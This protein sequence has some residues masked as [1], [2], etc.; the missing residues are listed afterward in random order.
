MVRFGRERDQDRL[1]ETTTGIPTV[2][3]RSG[4]LLA[5]FIRALRRFWHNRCRC[6]V[7]KQGLFSTDKL[8]RRA[9]EQPADHFVNVPSTLEL[10][11]DAVLSV[12]FV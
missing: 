2:A 9:V 8:G 6:G 5:R 7:P 1:T 4:G 3:A 10:L 11:V 12:T